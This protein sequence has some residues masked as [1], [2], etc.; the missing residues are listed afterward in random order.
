MKKSSL[1][2]T[3]AVVAVFGI[4]IFAIV[5]SIINKPPAVDS[6]WVEAMTMGPKDAK[7]RYVMY[8]DI[9]C[10]YCDVFTRAV[11]KN[12]ENFEKFLEENHVLFEIRMTN[13]LSYNGSAYSTAAAESA[14]CAAYENKFWEFYH[15]AIQALWNDYHSK[16]IGDSKTSP[17]IDDLPDDYWNNIAHNIG[18]G[19]SF[20]TCLA[21]EASKK[22]VDNFTNAASRI[23]SGFPYFV[24]GR[25][26]FS[27]LP[28]LDLDS[29]DGL[30][31]F[32]STGL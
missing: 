27:G 23:V 31:S 3:L 4:V 13:S 28:S 20:D 16:G 10:P 6:A 18:L 30:K 12:E 7:K 19:E 14:Y 21:T 24:F 9:M 22:D 32:L 29:W 26:T 5:N 8:T 25:Q 15:G 17:K 1:F 11:M 2:T